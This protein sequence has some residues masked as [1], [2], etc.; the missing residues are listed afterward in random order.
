MN[1]RNLTRLSTTLLIVVLLQTP[2]AAAAEIDDLN[3]WIRLDIP[4]SYDVE[5]GLVA[6]DSDEGECQLLDQDWFEGS[7]IG[8]ECSLSSIL[9]AVNCVQVGVELEA[10]GNGWIQAGAYCDG[11]PQASCGLYLGG[12]SG[13]CADVDGG[14]GSDPFYCWVGWSGSLSWS[15]T[16]TFWYQKSAES[17][18]F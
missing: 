6:S 3:P 5:T 13:R 16:C 12:G 18:L 2:G 9:V 8:L 14:G 15:V 17:D 1:T 4:I 10:S 7:S 11:G